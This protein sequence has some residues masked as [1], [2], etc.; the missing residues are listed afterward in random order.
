MNREN[1]GKLWIIYV[2]LLCRCLGRFLLFTHFHHYLGKNSHFLGA[3]CS[4]AASN[5]HSS[6]VPTVKPSNQ[7]G[8][9]HCVC[10]SG[11]R[12]FFTRI[13]ILKSSWTQLVAAT[14]TRLSRFRTWIWQK[15]LREK[16]CK[17]VH[18]AGIGNQCFEHCQVL[19]DS[20]LLRW[21]FV[22]VSCSW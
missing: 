22:E 20:T 2:Y 10:R 21:R 8:S 12:P 6:T 16:C 5:A 18:L 17:S 15:L 19:K 4:N 3:K 1:L 11:I 9:L 7:R 13:R 14:A